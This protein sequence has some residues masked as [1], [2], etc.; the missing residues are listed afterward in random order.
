MNAADLPVSAL[1]WQRHAF[2]RAS[3]GRQHELAERA[4]AVDRFAHV[5]KIVAGIP[6]G[7]SAVALL[8]PQPTERVRR[9]SHVAAP[10]ACGAEPGSVSSRDDRNRVC[11]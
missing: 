8:T 1:M 10:R 9:V 6:E 11:I 4:V 7:N 3:L 2:A 5:A